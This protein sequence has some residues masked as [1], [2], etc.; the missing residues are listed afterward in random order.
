MTECHKLSSSVKTT[1]KHIGQPPSA[2]PDARGLKTRPLSNRVI[3]D[4]HPSETAVK[5][6][7]SWTTGTARVFPSMLVVVRDRSIAEDD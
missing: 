5:I 2:G 1:P 7:K 3:A 6:A 4:R